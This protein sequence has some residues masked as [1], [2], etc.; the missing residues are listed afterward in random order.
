MDQALPSLRAL[1]SA[2][3]TAWRSASL[4]TPGE[5]A[6]QQLHIDAPLGLRNPLPKTSSRTARDI[7]T[8]KNAHGWKDKWL[9]GQA[10]R[11]NIW[12]GEWSTCSEWRYAGKSLWSTLVPVRWRCCRLRSSTEQCRR[13]PAATGAAGRRKTISQRRGSFHRAILISPP[14]MRSTSRSCCSRARHR[15]RSTKETRS[16]VSN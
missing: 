9:H 15:R 2:L 14:R 13:H 11:E 1:P 3:A 7:E 10:E 12:H 6:R 5:R 8:K 16:W 4:V